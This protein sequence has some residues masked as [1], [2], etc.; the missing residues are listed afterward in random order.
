MKKAWLVTLAPMTRVVLDEHATDE[1]ITE[2]ACRQIEENSAEKISAENLLEIKEDGE[3]PYGEGRGEDFKRVKCREGFIISF[4]EYNEYHPGEKG[5]FLNDQAEHETDV[6]Y[7]DSECFRDKCYLTD[8]VAPYH[9]FKGVGS[10]FGGWPLGELEDAFIT[11]L[12][13]DPDEL[14]TAAVCAYIRAAKDKFV[15]LADG[16]KF[17]E[18][19]KEINLNGI[20]LGAIQQHA[21]FQEREGISDEELYGWARNLFSVTVSDKLVGRIVQ[22]AKKNSCKSEEELKSLFISWQEESF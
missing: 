13:C 16:R 4:R 18:I 1:Q 20:L 5:F 3:V 10:T 9:E 19:R 6:V 22:Y 12:D 8:E 17:P 7:I 14:E 21:E 15:N 2:L 11:A